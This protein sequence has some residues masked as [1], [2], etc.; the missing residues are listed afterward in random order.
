MF[1]ST[2][3]RLVPS[4]DKLS[5]L[6]PRKNPHLILLLACDGTALHDDEIQI[7]L[8]PL[9]EQGLVYLCTWGP[10]CERIHDLAGQLTLHQ[11]GD[12][13]VMTTWHKDE[14]L[15]ESVWFLIYC[16]IPANESFVNNCDQ[17]A[18]AIS[19]QSWY[20]QIESALKELQCNA[21]S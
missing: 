5:E 10:D 1:Q 7:A 15:E 2:L 9:F 11:L 4:L 18:V 12:D 6:L 3:V 21:L 8:R 17:I 16:A 19:S 20:Q 14:P 13:L